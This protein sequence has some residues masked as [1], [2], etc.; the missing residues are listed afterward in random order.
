VLYRLARLAMANE[1]ANVNHNINRHSRGATGRGR[2]EIVAR[3]RERGKYLEGTFYPEV[4]AA[5]TIAKRLRIDPLEIRGS[6]AGAFGLPQFLPTNYLKF[7][8]DA[9]GN[10][11]VSLFDPDDAISSCANY[12]KGH[13]WRPGLSRRDK[14]K[15]IWNYN[16][17]E[18]YVDAVLGLTD[19]LGQ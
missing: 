5:F 9:D 17:S 15:V 18:P 12:L 13:G 16:H 7:G 2:Q 10:G 6:G 11:R 4:H 8:V 19:R 14:R 3:T 1:P